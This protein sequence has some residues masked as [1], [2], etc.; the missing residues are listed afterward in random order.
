MPD[1]DGYTIEDMEKWQEKSESNIARLE[2]GIER[3]RE[4][5]RRAQIIIDD[6]KAKKAES[7]SSE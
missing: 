1:E 3:E 5:H 7:D 4:A 2:E 6:L